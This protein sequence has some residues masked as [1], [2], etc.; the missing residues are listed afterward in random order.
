MGSASRSEIVA[1]TD[2]A[3]LSVRLYPR[4]TMLM[5]LM[6]P[7]VRLACLAP[8]G[9]IYVSGALAGN[10]DKVFLIAQYDGTPCI[11]Q[12][13]HGYYP[14]D[15]MAQEFPDTASALEKVQRKIRARAAGEP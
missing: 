10:E 7:Y 11:M 12:G 8:D 4:L 15:W 3:R 5:A 14:A 13:G 1:A 6:P 2:S 9:R